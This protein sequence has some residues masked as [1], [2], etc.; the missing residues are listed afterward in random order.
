VNV[1]FHDAAEQ[2]RSNFMTGNPITVCIHYKTKE[3]IED[4]VFGLAVYEQGG[5]HLSG[6]NTNFDEFTIPAIEGEGVI[7]YHIPRLILLEGGYTLSVAVHN[8]ADTQM[9]DY[10]DRAYDFRVYPGESRERYGI[11]SLGGK[12]QLQEEDRPTPMVVANH[13]NGTLDDHQKLARKLK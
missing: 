10:H 13:V 3:R 7:R 5:T 8:R 12:W 2:P 9:Y 1:E 6:P 4:P 11:V